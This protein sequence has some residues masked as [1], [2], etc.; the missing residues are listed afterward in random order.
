M[1]RVGGAVTHLESLD[2]RM[3]EH[4][5]QVHTTGGSHGHGSNG[6]GHVVVLLAS[7]SGSTNDGYASC[8]SP[9]QLAH[10]KGFPEF[11]SLLIQIIKV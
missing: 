5:A 10:L 7:L 6:R 8:L 3:S 1:R 4:C 2:C 11:N 9:R